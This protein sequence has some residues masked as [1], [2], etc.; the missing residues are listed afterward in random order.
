MK[1]GS[2]STWVY[3]SCFSWFRQFSCSGECAQF[4]A[5]KAKPSHVR[6]PWGPLGFLLIVRILL[7][8][9][10]SLGTDL[11]LKILFGAHVKNESISYIN[12]SF[13]ICV[14]NDT[15][16]FR[17]PWFIFCKVKVKRSKH[18]KA[19]FRKRAIWRKLA[20]GCGYTYLFSHSSKFLLASSMYGLSSGEQSSLLRCTKP[21]VCPEN[22]L[23]W[24]STL[25]CSFSFWVSKETW[26]A[27][28]VMKT[29]C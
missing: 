11:L 16:N 15:M 10:N 7:Y 14:S 6:V 4:K 25:Q 18:V 26:L 27:K 17:I 1:V 28:D 23:I 2:C 22:V 13:L 8:C 9:P 24:Y 3:L 21:C 19:H 20:L 29:G 5:R 12:F